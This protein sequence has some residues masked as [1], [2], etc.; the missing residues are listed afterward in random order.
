M[1]SHAN[2]GRALLLDIAERQKALQSP[3]GAMAAEQARA[4]ENYEKNDAKYQERSALYEKAENEVRVTRTFAKW[5]RVIALV[6]LAYI[7]YRVSR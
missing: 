3:L 2:E 6:L 4:L 5:A 7:A 1:N